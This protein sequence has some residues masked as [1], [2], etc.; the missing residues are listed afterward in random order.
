VAQVTARK[1]AQAALQR[2]SGESFHSAVNR[3]EE[4]D[5][6]IGISFVQVLE[7]AERVQFGIVPDEDFH[8]VLL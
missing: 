4:A 7:V 2:L 8:A 5:G 6:G 1:A 3:R